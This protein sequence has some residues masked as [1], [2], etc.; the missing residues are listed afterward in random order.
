MIQVPFWSSNFVLPQLWKAWFANRS[1][2]CAS[3]QPSIFVGHTSRDTHIAKSEENSSVFLIHF[4][5]LLSALREDQFASVN[6]EQAFES[7][8]LMQEMVCGYLCDVMRKI[9]IDKKGKEFR[10]QTNVQ[11]RKGNTQMLLIVCWFSHT[12]PAGSPIHLPH[13]KQLRRIQK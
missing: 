12:S 10:S 1:T 9:K 7:I 13:F 6:F 2:V 8:T 3:I 4:F 11:H 5:V